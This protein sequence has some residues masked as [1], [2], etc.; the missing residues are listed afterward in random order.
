MVSGV[1]NRSQTWAESAEDPLISEGKLFICG[2]GRI[3]FSALL[4]TCHIPRAAEP[5]SGWTSEAGAIRFPGLPLLAVSCGAGRSLTK[6]RLAGRGALPGSAGCSRGL[7]CPLVSLAAV[8]LPRCPGTAGKAPAASP[9][10]LPPR[11]SVRDAPVHPARGT[12]RSAE[13]GG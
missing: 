11:P 6:Q 7:R 13:P 1:M 10:A 3:C 5:G 9:E 8:A 4:A 12:E 2:T